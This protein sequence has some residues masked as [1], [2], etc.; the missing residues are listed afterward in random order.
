MPNYSHAELE[1]WY[2]N[3]AKEVYEKSNIDVT[4]KEDLGRIKNYYIQE[5]E[6]DNPLEALGEFQYAYIPHNELTYDNPPPSIEN[7]DEYLQW[8]MDNLQIPTTDEQIEKLMEMSKAGTLMIIG[9]GGSDSN[10]RQVYT[11]ELGN[12]KTTLPLDMMTSSDKD[13]IP[14]ERRLPAHPIFPPDEANPTEFG[15]NDCPPKPVKPKNMNPSFLSWLGYVLFRMDN[16]YAKMVRYQK[17][18]ATYEERW[19]KWYEGLDD[20]KDG[21]SEY[22]EAKHA[23]DQYLQQ[24]EEFKS[25][26]LGLASAIDNGYR[27]VVVS[28]NMAEDEDE[29]G[30]TPT[31]KLKIKETEFMKKQHAK[32]P[33]GKILKNL[34]KVNG[35]LETANRTRR[36]VKN[37]V[38]HDPDPKALTEWLARG[39]FLKSDYAPKPYDL[40]NPP[41]DA[42]LTEKE[43]T[44]F[45]QKYRDLSE[46]AGFAALMHPEVSGNPPVSGFTAEE[47]TKLNYTMIL[48]NLF[49]GG[50]PSS[51]N[52]MVY[53]EPAR[54]KAQQAVEAYHNGD[55]SLLADLLRNSIRQTNRE[56]ACIPVPGT[57]HGLNTLY[58]IGR[59]WNTMQQDPKLMNAVGLTKEEIKETQAN[60]ALHKTL[61]KALEAK[62]ALLEYSLYRREM[63][64]EQLKQAACDVLFGN[65]AHNNV[66][67]SYKE[68]TD[69]IEA[70]PEHKAIMQTIA[71][72]SNIPKKMEEIE[73]A[74]KA[75]DMEAVALKQAELENMPR[76]IDE[77]QMRCNLLLF[78]RPGH[79]SIQNLLDEN[80]VK[81]VK[82]ALRNDPNLDSIVTMSRENVG[83]LLTTKNGFKDAFTPANARSAESIQEEKVQVKENPV[84][85]LN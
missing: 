9:P 25:N 35:D 70:T 38:G 44:V 37:L 2:R 71:D 11:D 76:K 17:E 73:A 4:R 42:N 63:N 30:M 47:I 15:L 58:L 77:A 5:W 60:I 85:G 66:M 78:K 34:D 61:T 16:D 81:N 12:I 53:M 50:R 23:R 40:P 28:R 51:S 24:V 3:F 52:Y 84:I 65:I 39:V 20:S 26:H 19:N 80:W 82:S 32:L 79:A 33:Q 48:N 22:K 31:M 45:E 83:N 57:D 27:A 13:D 74:K 49:T 68:Q 59:L 75:G 1:R 43:K 62:Q 64:P 14:Q 10:M 8:V 55:V 69:R 6:P 67:L 36:V 29:M 21:V 46:I 7:P 18:S 56:A 54:V 72:N 41:E